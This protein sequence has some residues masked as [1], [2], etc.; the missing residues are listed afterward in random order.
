MNKNLI[1]KKKKNKIYF[2]VIFTIISTILVISIS[3]KSSNL[4]FLLLFEILLIAGIMSEVSSY[5]FLNKIK[6]TRPTDFEEIIFW[7]NKNCIFTEKYILFWKNSKIICY[8]YRELKKFYKEISY[9]RKGMPDILYMTFNKN[10]TYEIRVY[11]NAFIDEKYPTSK[12][13]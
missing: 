13:I 7:N 4:L 8:E 3:L 5:V 1:I 12:N 9:T 11:S 10:E 6:N 2:E